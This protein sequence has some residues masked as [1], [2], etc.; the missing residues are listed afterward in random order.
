MDLLKELEGAKTIAIS[1]HVRPD[2]DCVGSVMSMYTYL[3]KAMPEAQVVAML[4]TPPAKFDVVPRIN[5]LCTDFN[6]G[7]T[8]FDAFV[9][10]DSSTIDRYGD[11]V[12]FYESAKK[13]I[14]ID[15]H[16]SNDGFGD[17]SLVD[18]GASS[19]SE[20]A[21][22]LY[23]KKYIDIDIATQLYIGIMDDTGV[24][25]YANVKPKT[26]RIVA[27]LIEYGFDFNALIDGIFYTKTR[28]Q[29]EMLGRGLVESIVFDDGRCVVS[30]ID[31]KTMEF[32]GA[33]SSDLDG[34]VSQLKY[35]KGV[36]VAIFMYEMEPLKYKVSLRSNGRVDVAKI[37]KFYNGGGHVRAAGMA[38][39]GTFHDCINNL[40]DSI[41]IQL[42]KLN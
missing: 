19:A 38:M 33:Q 10:L 26:L 14:V 41:N 8:E 32:Y 11:A 24:F 42:E 35:T 39:E 1:G 29:N 16:V 3:T 7:I 31:K 15:H 34:I 6:P 40:S 23:E 5:E 17:V 21:Y 20:I 2:G 18:G 9:G 12:R 4:E 13:R 36:E 22:G 27:D 25:Q 37:A 28:V 30:K